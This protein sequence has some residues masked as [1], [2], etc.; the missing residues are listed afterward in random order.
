MIAR[1][2]CTE[3][4]RSI[5]ETSLGIGYA[6]A[7]AILAGENAAALGEAA[8]VGAGTFAAA[9]SSG[10][11]GGD[12][13]IVFGDYEV[14]SGLLHAWRSHA[15]EPLGPHPYSHTIEVAFERAL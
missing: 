4:Q 13:G 7:N 8:E 11:S 12:C 6:P 14:E 3:H 5:P 15:I 10:A 9:N 2:N 1:D